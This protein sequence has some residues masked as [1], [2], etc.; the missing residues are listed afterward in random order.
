M[1]YSSLLVMAQLTAGSDNKEDDL[2]IP[3]SAWRVLA[4]ACIVFVTTTPYLSVFELLYDEQLNQTG[5]PTSV[6]TWTFTTFLIMWN[7]TSLFVGP[8]CILKSHRW[9]TIIGNIL[10]GSGA[11]L[12]AFGKSPADLYLSVG[13]IAGSG[14]GLVTNTTILL[15]VDH[16]GKK[17][18]LAIGLS[19]MIMA[20]SGI[21]SPQIVNGLLHKFSAKN[22]V[23][24]YGCI[25]LLGLGGAFLFTPVA[26]AAPSDSDEVDA[27]HSRFNHSKHSQRVKHQLSC[28]GTATEDK[29]R[30]IN[31]LK[32]NPLVQM[33]TLIK[34]SLLK[35]P[36]FL[37]TVL[38][39]SYSFN[40]LLTFYLFLPLYADSRG[41]TTD[42]KSVLLSVVSGID[43][44]TR[45]LFAWM[46]DWKFI[47]RLF[48]QQPR[49]MLYAISVIGIGSV[50]IVLP[51]EKYYNGIVVA[52]VL[53]GIF[54]GGIPGNG[55]M[56]YS[57]SF[58]EDL[59]SAMGLASIGRALAALSMGPLAHV[60]KNREDGVQISLWF[61]GAFSIFWMVLWCLEILFCQCGYRP[62]NKDS[63]SDGHQMAQAAP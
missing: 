35:S 10:M 23:I 24:I 7:F 26:E 19:F 40:C 11:I 52:C 32:N 5:N 56:V 8:L 38:G 60:A 34:W 1:S 54:A 63:D 59:P 57:E 36:R 21:I 51:F 45:F 15:L 25:M 62:L 2:K 48:C 41:C 49:R 58:R 6:G 27:V 29:K 37:L 30:T 46:G 42:Q 47:Q 55:P 53:Y 4:G 20:I 43:L 18:G 33:F 61:T 12:S 50:M 17:Q 22:T 28:N 31:R 13:L 39:S 44:V 16:F 9:T 3:N 14:Q